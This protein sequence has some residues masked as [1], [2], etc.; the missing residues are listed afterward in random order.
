MVSLISTVTLRLFKLFISNHR[1]YM[2]KFSK[3]NWSLIHGTVKSWIDFDRKS[4]VNLRVISSMIVF[5]TGFSFNELDARHVNRASW[6]KRLRGPNSIFSTWTFLLNAADDAV[7]C[8]LGV[9]DWPALLALKEGATVVE[10]IGSLL[11]YQTTFGAGRPPI[12]EHLITTS[13]PASSGLILNELIGRPISS[14]IFGS[15]GGTGIFSKQLN[16]S[17]CLHLCNSL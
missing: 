2:M 6:W 3:T 8:N 10:G 9:L 15:D 17:I 12:T 11:R 16:Y 7:E 5:D 4:V 13:F 14:P 1:E